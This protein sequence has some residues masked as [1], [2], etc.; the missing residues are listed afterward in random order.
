MREQLLSLYETMHEDLTTLIKHVET[1]D[2]EAINK[3]PKEEKW[4]AQQI[5][6]HLILAEKHSIAYCIKKLSFDPKLK[7]A[8][9]NSILKE[10]LVKSYFILPLKL[11]APKGIDTPNLPKKD[12]LENIKQ[13][14]LYNR[15]QMKRFLENVDEKYLDREL[16]KH[17]F[18]G[19]LSLKVMLIFFISHFRHHRKQIYDALRVTTQP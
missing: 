7:K 19:R 2:D 3:A 15:D 14:W 9:I 12:D 11:E 10:W 17:P 1:Y 6:N 13:N 8:G 18:A 16:Y 4:S 5:M